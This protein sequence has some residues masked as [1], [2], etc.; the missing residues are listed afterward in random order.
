MTHGLKAKLS[1]ALLAA[2][3][4][5]ALTA[6]AANA[7]AL[8]DK[9]CSDVHL[10][11][12]A[13]GAEGDAFASIVYNGAVQAAHD[14]GAKVEYVFSG[15]KAE[16]MVQQLREAIATKPAGIAM[17]G[18]PGEVGD[19]AAGRTGIQRRHQDDVPERP[20]AGRGRQV[21]RRL[22]GRPAGPAGQGPG[23]GSR[24]AASG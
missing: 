15:W 23:R 22:C 17:M 8:R 1:G 21:R 2:V 14:T 24:S 4:V 18:H 20:A 16:T 11:F 6:T 19:H 3:S 12:F 7:E 5:L 9:W 13:G 10:R